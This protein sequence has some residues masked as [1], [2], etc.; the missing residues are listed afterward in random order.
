MEEQ[1]LP[2]ET[3]R[4]LEGISKRITRGMV[5]AQGTAVRGSNALFCGGSPR[6]VPLPL[7]LLWSG[8]SVLA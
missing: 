1:T 7:L 2:R 4:K 8:T 6:E 3:L 5:G